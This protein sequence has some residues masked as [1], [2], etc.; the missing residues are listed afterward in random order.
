MHMKRF[1]QTV[2]FCGLRSVFPCI[3]PTCDLYGLTD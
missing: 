1:T 2:L 3:P